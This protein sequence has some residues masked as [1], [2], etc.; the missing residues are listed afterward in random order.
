MND[1]DF[2]AQFDYLYWLRDRILAQATKLKPEAWI[3]TDT[4][5]SRDLR[6]T[7][8]HELDVELSWRERLRGAL[9]ENWRDEVIA[10]DDYPTLEALADRWRSDEAEMR[11]WVAS[12]G[13]HDLSRPV[14]VN[15]LRGY[16][17]SI[18]LL[19]VIDHGIQS[20]SEAAVLLSAAGHSPGDLDFL[21]FYDSPSR[22]S[23]LP[24]D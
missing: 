10:A 8:V 11:A 19:H 22:R 3:A 24:A 12:L 2:A 15:Q 17:M 5:T 4:V 20:F 6:A 23:S 16:P 1:S 7:L 9:P 13:E 18:H 14:R 21:D